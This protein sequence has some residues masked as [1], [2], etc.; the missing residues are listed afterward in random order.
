MKLL[1]VQVFAAAMTIGFAG[2]GFV[3]MNAVAKRKELERK[4]AE[5]DAHAKIAGGGKAPAPAAGGVKPKPAGGR[6]LEKENAEF[7]RRVRDLELRVEG[8]KR[9]NQTLREAAA[10]AA[11][12]GPNPLAAR[13]S[14]GAPPNPN[15][16]PEIALTDAQRQALA[17]N[18]PRPVAG[19]EPN[20]QPWGAAEDGEID[21][22]SRAL[23][24]NPEQRTEVKKI[25]LESQNEFER[26]LIEAS[27]KGER[28]ITII[29]RIGDDVS[30]KTQQR[31]K[32][33]LS[34]EQQKPFDDL[35]REKE[36]KQ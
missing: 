6:D 36:G 29:E 3:A 31:I 26:R 10:K 25:I 27:Q 12:S 19:G 17:Q 22:M 14:G 18:P 35:M 2:T 28:D 23:K 32:Q 33:I 13:I 34:A 20:A 5:R 21:E 1:Y 4:L 30:Q 15:A 9:E 24:L 16:V 11:P 8:L 7:A